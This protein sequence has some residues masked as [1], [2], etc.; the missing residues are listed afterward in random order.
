[1]CRERERERERA[2]LGHGKWWLLLFL[3]VGI[4]F[5]FLNWRRQ[6]CAVERLSFA[7]GAL[8]FVFVFFFFFGPG[9][10]KQTA[11]TDGGREGRSEEAAARERRVL[12]WRGE[13]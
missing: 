8:S 6:V 9:F 12:V 13:W 11:G 2:S 7:V 4:C 5:W 1:M 3:R 10:G